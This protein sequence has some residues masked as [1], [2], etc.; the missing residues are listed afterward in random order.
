[1]ERWRGE[2]KKGTKRTQDTKTDVNMLISAPITPNLFHRSPIAPEYFRSENSDRTRDGQD[3]GEG[4][5]GLG[6]AVNE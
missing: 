5:G 2:G 1:M 6:E 3:G 4:K